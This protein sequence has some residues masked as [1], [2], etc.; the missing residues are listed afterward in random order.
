MTG[1]VENYYQ[2]Y[3]NH[4]KNL[5]SIDDM[6]NVKSMETLFKKEIIQ[7]PNWLTD[8]Q[9]EKIISGIY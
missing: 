7:S 6:I 4:L 3:D 2:K 8:L 9:V 1:C 5:I